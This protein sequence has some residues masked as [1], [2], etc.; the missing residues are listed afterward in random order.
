MES[1]SEISSEVKDILSILRN[2]SIRVHTEYPYDNLSDQYN[3]NITENDFLGGNCVYL[4]RLFRSLMESINGLDQEKCE[5]LVS[6]KCS[7]G[8]AD[9]KK[10]NHVIVVYDKVFDR[11]C[12]K[13]FRCI[14]ASE[15][16]NSCL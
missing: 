14:H 16:G 12:W 4:C 6:R 1:T 8:L 11:A 7:S 2:L 3:R 13:Q 5:L 9:E 10:V 15:R